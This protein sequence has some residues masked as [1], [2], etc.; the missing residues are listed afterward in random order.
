MAVAELVHSVLGW[1]VVVRL[2]LFDAM[3]LLP[4]TV[5]TLWLNFLPPRFFAVALPTF[6]AWVGPFFDADLTPALVQIALLSLLVTGGLRRAVLWPAV[7]PGSRRAKL[8][9]LSLFLGAPLIWTSR[10]ASSSARGAENR[11]ALDAAFPLPAEAQ[12]HLPAVYDWY[13]HL[14]NKFGGMPEIEANRT[15]V[16]RMASTSRP[17]EECLTGSFQSMPGDTSFKDYRKDIGVGKLSLDVFEPT[18][19]VK[20]RY[21]PRPVLLHVHG[22]GWRAGVRWFIKFN[23][24]G[25]I[26]HFLLAKGYTIVSVSYRLSCTGATPAD[27]VDDVYQAIEY[28]SA[29]ANEWEADGSRVVAFGTSAGGNIVL[30]AALMNPPESLKGVVSLYGV[31]EL[32]QDRLEAMATSAFE[33]V[34]GYVFGLASRYVCEHAQDKPD[35]FRRASPLWYVEEKQADAVQRVPVVLLHGREDPLV[36]ASQSRAL[37]DALREKGARVALVDVHGSHDCDVHVSSACSQA[38]MFSMERL[39]LFVDHL[40]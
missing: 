39:L 9:T 20:A 26:P 4:R 7:G 14:T 32:R 29:H 28:V 31:S 37:A 5:L 24:H 11:R 10:V 22:G 12:A 23:Y 8:R 17:A 38:A 25:G 1:L 6:Y 19:E 13:A 33:R 27:M 35:C 30:N 40:K 2:L 15:V 36:L 21:G 16:F 34:H 18:P 3:H